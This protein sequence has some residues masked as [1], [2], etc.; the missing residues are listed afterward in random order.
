MHEKLDQHQKGHNTPQ[1]LHQQLE[2]EHRPRQC[3]RLL[4]LSPAADQI[5]G[6]FQQRRSGAM[7][8]LGLRLS[9]KKP[10]PTETELASI[11]KLCAE[12]NKAKR[13]IA[14]L[15]RQLHKKT[16]EVNLLKKRPAVENKGK[17]KRKLWETHPTKFD[18]NNAA[19]FTPKL[20]WL[21]AHGPDFA[22][23]W[24]W[25]AWISEQGIEHLHH[26]LNKQ[27]ERFMRYKGDELL[28]KI[29]EHQTLLNSIFNR[30]QRTGTN[31]VFLGA[32]GLS[33]GRTGQ[34]HLAKIES[35]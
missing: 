6:H 2:R 35:I 8:A 33:I 18:T 34:L 14:T 17:L 26:V 22:K 21:L 12:L 4:I 20:H 23:R 1:K 13:R 30:R 27:S 31:W 10:A 16:E 11:Q 25:F 15:E 32:G 9:T 28:L 29:G 19:G 24:G 5:Q 7:P 3:R